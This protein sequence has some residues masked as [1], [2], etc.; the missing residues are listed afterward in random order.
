MKY[1]KAILA[2]AIVTAIVGAGAGLAAYLVG[3]VVVA[4]LS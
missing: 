1:V 2:L 3:H 4:L